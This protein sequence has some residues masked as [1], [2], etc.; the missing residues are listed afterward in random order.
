MS[1]AR[2]GRLPLYQS[3][4]ETLD[5]Q[6][7]S[8]GTPI[9]LPHVVGPVPDWV[10]ALRWGGDGALPFAAADEENGLYWS[11]VYGETSNAAAVFKTMDSYSTTAPVVDPGNGLT[12]GA[13]LVRNDTIPDGVLAEGFSVFARV[14]KEAAG[15]LYFGLLNADNTAYL[16]GGLDDGID[17]WDSNGGSYYGAGASVESRLNV[18]AARFPVGGDPLTVYANG[19]LGAGAAAVDTYTDI[20]FDA[21]QG[22]TAVK[23]V[24]F[25]PLQPVDG[26]AEMTQVPWLELVSILAGSGTILQDRTAIESHFS[27]KALGGAAPLIF[28]V[29]SGELPDG[30]TFDEN[31]LTGTPAESG[32]F[33]F[34]LQVEDDDGQQATVEVTFT[35]VTPV[36]LLS[37]NP[38]TPLQGEL[39]NYQFTYSGIGEPLASR[40]GFELHAGEIGD[41]V[42]SAYFTFQPGTSD[43]PNDRLQWDSVNLGTYDFSIHLFDTGGS[44]SDDT[45]R[46]HWEVVAR[47]FDPLV[48]TSASP[49]PDGFADGITA[50]A[51]AIEGDNFTYGSDMAFAITDGTVPAGAFFDGSHNFCVNALVE[52]GDYTFTV[53]ATRHADG[54]TATKEF[55]LHVAGESF[56]MPDPQPSLPA[57]TAGVPYTGQIDKTGTAYF[58]FYLI[59]GAGGSDMPTGLTVDPNTGEVSLPVPVSGHYGFTAYTS[60]YF[61]AE[62]INGIDQLSVVVEWDIA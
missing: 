57:P 28:S 1:R 45:I 61:E 36:T 10:E 9:P 22:T 46:V 32:D 31:G 40:V 16:D 35:V 41:N 33:D 54:A 18:V 56:T 42:P 38:P 30:V 19:A 53:E 26:M 37:R 14:N 7:F 5:G 51:Y 13:R 55:T 21:G 25:Y 58:Y 47:E 2:R 17:L 27:V 44:P 6:I 11:A 15:Y 52:P 43:Q 49:M 3:V 39:Y 12:E 20:G 23:L 8:G 34:V 24:A 62:H 59:G 4:A 50:Y 29:L 48:I 60:R